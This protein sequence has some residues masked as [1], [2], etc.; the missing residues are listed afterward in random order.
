MTYR[1]CPPV[2]VDLF[3]FS[4]LK[5]IYHFSYIDQYGLDFS[6]RALA[7]YPCTT[8]MKALNVSVNPK[9]VDV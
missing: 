4:F 6:K 3:I 2:Y 1:A 5:R 8:T 7:I 9:Y